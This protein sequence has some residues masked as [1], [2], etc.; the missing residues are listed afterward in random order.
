MGTS[1]WQNIPFCVEALMKIAPERVLD[2][3]IGFGRWGIVVREFCDVWYGRITPDAWSVHVEG[4][5][6][7][8]GNV[9]PYHRHFYSNIH[10]VDA[11]DYFRTLEAR[12][13]VI[14]FGDVIEHFP[15]AVGREL[16]EKSVAS[17]TYTLVNVPL[18]E[19][20]HQEETYEN[21]YERHLAA[22]SLDDFA[23]FPVVRSAFFTDYA[24]RP[25]AS[26]VISANDPKELAAQ[27]FSKTTA[28]G[29]DG[30]GTEAIEEKMQH[31]LRKTADLRAELDFIRQHSSYR[32]ATRLR[33]SPAW[34]ALR[35]LRT[36]NA[37]LLTIRALGSK[38]PEAKGAEVWLLAARRAAHSPAIPWDLMETPEG[39][40]ERPAAPQGSYGVAL[41][42][43]TGRVRFPVYDPDPMLTF[44]AHPWG[45][46]VEISYRGRRH[47]I[48]LY[49]ADADT[50]HV[51]PTREPSS[52]NGGTTASLPARSNGAS[53]A[54]TGH[55]QFSPEE[56][57]WLREIRAKSVPVLAI[58][59]PRWLGVTA[60]TQVLFEDLFPFPWSADIDPAHVGPREVQHQ[61]RLIIESGIRHLVCSG[62]ES[63]HYDLIREIKREAPDVRCD[64]LW[65]GSYVQ[66]HEDRVWQLSKLWIAAAK[67]GLIHTIGTVKKGM[68]QFFESLGCRSRFVM[69]YVPEVPEGPSRPASGGPHL[70]LWISGYT[71]RKL[72]F[73][74]LA[75][76]KMIP[77]AV[78]HGSNFVPRVQEVL[79]VLGITTGSI[80]DN[81]LQRPALLDT[82]R[83]THLS[84]YVTF[85]ECSPMLPLE[86]LSVGV[87]CLT[88]PTSH[89]FED[90]DFLH[91]RLVVP[92]PDRADVIAEYITRALAE[93]ERIVAAYRAYAPGYNA[94]ARESVRRF[95]R[96]DA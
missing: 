96:D 3:G 78:L 91:R 21:P 12:F 53:A 8:P 38:H 56:Q 10:V 59:V 30:D 65:H 49:S 57:A 25:F 66:W 35:W 32:L 31:V 20:W 34:N 60:A 28:V 47:L 71:Y 33:S 22:W 17:S 41:K 81:A 83:Q 88:G 69:N 76:V 4:L 87:P 55:P 5:E 68:E 62:G 13:D 93:R 29:T 43:T 72:P 26:L 74:M 48:D 23:A 94:R 24:L 37:D 63:L 67:D 54:A 40:W 79:E 44:M 85:S 75:A 82:I 50:I 92:Y 42:G 16:L 64:L 86:S 73:A 1:N 9:R 6:A 45:G 19:D 18:G 95:L 70:G 39:P 46:N 14:I 52:T 15:K 11:A 90:D 36:R 2:V 89:L 61:A 51:W 80:T 84:L 7:F 27:L 77:G 58:H